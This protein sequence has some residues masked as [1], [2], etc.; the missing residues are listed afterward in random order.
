MLD[1]RRVGAA[2]PEA[3]RRRSPLGHNSFESLGSFETFGSFIAARKETFAMGLNAND[4]NA[5][6]PNDP[7]V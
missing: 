5:N 1:P 4:P 7:N 6:D 2:S 3:A